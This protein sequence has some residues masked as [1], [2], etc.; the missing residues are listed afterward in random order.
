MEA[1]ERTPSR[2]GRTTCD[3]RTRADGILS[4]PWNATI[5]VGFRRERGVH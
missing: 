4:P 2:S 5:R 1:F 3:P